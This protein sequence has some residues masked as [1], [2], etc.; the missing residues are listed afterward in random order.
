LDQAYE[1]KVGA[2]L[3]TLT[4]KGAWMLSRSG[5]LDRLDLAD[6][7]NLDVNERQWPRFL[8]TQDIKRLRK[9]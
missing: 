2:E 9:I 6:K 8:L 5:A 1:L 4:G 3:K 7:V